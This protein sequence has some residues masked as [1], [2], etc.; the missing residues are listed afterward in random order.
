MPGLTLTRKVE[1]CCVLP[2]HCRYVYEILENILRNSILSVTEIPHDVSHF[3]FIYYRKANLHT[4]SRMAEDFSAS[5]TVSP[6]SGHASDGVAAASGEDIIDAPA[7]VHELVCQCRRGG[8][9]KSLYRLFANSKELRWM[10]ADVSRTTSLSCV[11]LEFFFAH[12]LTTLFS[13]TCK[14]L[15]GL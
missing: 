4:D 14:S 9:C 3:L 6:T 15:P 8:S 13:Y 7:R 5:R 11:N 12:N 2:Q 1:Q 10:I